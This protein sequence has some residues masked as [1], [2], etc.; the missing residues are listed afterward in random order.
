ML[1]IDAGRSVLSM[2]L[3]FSPPPSSSSGRD[4]DD[5][6]DEDPSEAD[7]LEDILIL[8]PSPSSKRLEVGNDKDEEVDIEVGEGGGRKVAEECG[9]K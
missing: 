1:L 5:D 3:L 6:D 8:Q 2:L 7:G 9:V 4:L